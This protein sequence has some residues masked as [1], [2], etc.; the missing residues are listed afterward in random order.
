MSNKSVKDEYADVLETKR[1]LHFQRMEEIIE[2]D[3]EELSSINFEKILV[4]LS[5]KPGNKYKFITK[6]GYSFK[7]ALLCFK[8]SGRQKKFLIRGM[9]PILFNCQRGNQV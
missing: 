5:K 9:S 8:L 3:I 6:A 7:L 1:E 4:A 2:E